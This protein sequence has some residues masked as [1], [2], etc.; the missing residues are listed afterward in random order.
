[1]FR[2]FSRFD[3]RYLGYSWKKSPK[4]PITKKSTDKKTYLYLLN[5]ENIVS[6]NMCNISNKIKRC[7]FRINFFTS[8]ID[9]LEKYYFQLKDKQIHVLLV[10]LLV[11]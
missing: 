5:A 11:G 8:S 6:T 10:K 4:L 9:N 7:R 1:M 3:Y 2:Y